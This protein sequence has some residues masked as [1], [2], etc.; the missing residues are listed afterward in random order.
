MCNENGNDELYC[1][2]T[3]EINLNQIASIGL[4][5]RCLLTSVFRQIHK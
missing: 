2:K 1:C 3:A 4:W 5:Y